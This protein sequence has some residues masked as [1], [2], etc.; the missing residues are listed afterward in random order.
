MRINALVGVAMLL[1]VTIGEA[2]AQG[3]GGGDRIPP[4]IPLSP[5][6]VNKG[7]KAPDGIG[8]AVRDRTRTV[9]EMSA[10]TMTY[11]P[12]E[13]ASVINPL[14]VGASIPADSDVLTM[15]GKPFSLNDAVAS[16]PTVLIFYRGGWCPYC[17]A[18]LR[19]LRDSMPA[20]KEMG[21]QLLAISP[22]TP[23]QLREMDKDANLGY[24]L[25]S[26]A[27]V[28]VGEA[29][30]LRYK[31]TQRYID[32]VMSVQGP[33]KNLGKQ[34]DGYM[35][36]PGAFVLGTDGVIKFAY[37]NNNY[38]VRVGQEALLDAARGALR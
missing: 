36:T 16:Q 30:G 32:H 12:W 22:D 34:N 5:E 15:D 10:E 20:L 14:P 26:D 29:F 28:S 33:E 27:G 21:Y 1:L 37:V 38:T 17:N 9:G 4:P 31:L 6:P 23:E 8:E 25:L 3:H 13:D 18:H 24:Q 35:L 2:E 7:A 11:T 19:Q